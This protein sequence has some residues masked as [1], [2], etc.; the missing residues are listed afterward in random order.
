MRKE[1][2]LAIVLGV[3][4]GVVIIFGINLANQSSSDTPTQPG[5][6][7]TPTTSLT[8]TPTPSLQIVAPNN[9]SVSFEDTVTLVGKAK[10]ESWIAIIWEENENIIQSDQS[11]SFSQEISL[12]GGE[13]IIQITATNGQDYQE[14][15]NIT[16]IYTTAEI[17]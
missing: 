9:N 11:G 10:P 8:P 4:L 2:I 17:Q 3:I 12:I 13:N 6:Q 15:T 1:I 14:S 5:S 7:A 16:I